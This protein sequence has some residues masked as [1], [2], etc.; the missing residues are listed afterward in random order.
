MT[1]GRV[2]SGRNTP[3]GSTLQE[4]LPSRTLQERRRFDL[5]V[6]GIN[7]ESYTPVAT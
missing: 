2:S 3:E 7:W 6:D 1:E 5:D 4:R